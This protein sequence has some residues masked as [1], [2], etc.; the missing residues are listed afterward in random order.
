MYES[1]YG[2]GEKPFALKP[3]PHFLYMST[4]HQAAL[5]LLEYGIT[6]E[7][8]FVVI[9]GEVGSGKTTLIRHFLSGV[10]AGVTIGV[11]TNTHPNFGELLH[12]VLLAFGLDYKTKE[13]VE[14]YHTFVDF[15]TGEYAA[16]RRVVLIVDE[17]QNLGAE[18]LEEL[19]TLSNVNAEQAQFLQIVLAGQPELAE[20]LKRPELRQFAQRISSDYKLL[21]LTFDETCAY[22]RHRLKVAGGDPNL[23]DEI[24]CRAVH[25]FTSGVP[26]LINILCD[27]SLVYGFAQEKKRIDCETVLRVIVDKKQSGLSSLAQIAEKLSPQEI[28]LRISALGTAQTKA[29][30]TPALEAV[31]NEMRPAKDPK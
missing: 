29:A 10:E 4:R 7:A 8:G 21:P 2:F 22:I 15:V 20:T 17:A 1:F 3:D 6:E 5:S 9:T 23:F 18:A 28:A 14:L 30:E 12:W 24:A 27:T 31:Q 25:I 13:K 19:R 16:R 26:R 11:I